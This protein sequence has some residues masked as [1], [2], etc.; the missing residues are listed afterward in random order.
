MHILKSSRFLMKWFILAAASAVLPPW[1]CVAH[2]TDMEIIKPPVQTYAV[3][4]ITG[5]TLSNGSYVADIALDDVPNVA[6][7]TYKND[8]QSY[9]AYKWTNGVPTLGSTVSLADQLTNYPWEGTHWLY[10]GPQ[11]IANGSIAL[12]KQTYNPD[13]P[14]PWMKQLQEPFLADGGEPGRVGLPS[15]LSWIGT[16]TGYGGMRWIASGSAYAFMAEYSFST[17]DPTHQD[18]LGSGRGKCWSSFIFHNG[19]YD[20]FLMPNWVP[21]NDGTAHV[22]N[23]IP[24]I[25]NEQGCGCGWDPVSTDQT[26]NSTQ[27]FWDGRAFSSPFGSLDYPI[28][29]NDQNQVA[30]QAYDSEY[31]STEGYM[32]EPSTVTT[33]RWTLPASMMWQVKS[34]QPI[35]ISNQV[36]PDLP[37]LD[38]TIHILSDATVL[39]LGNS[40]TPGKLV[41]KRDN[42]E[43]WSFSLVKLP[44]QTTI[45]DW[46]TIN[47]RGIIS[48]IGNG[49][50]ALLLLPEDII[51]VD[52]FI[53]QT[54]VEEPV[55]P[56]HPGTTYID[57]GNSRKDPLDSS[58]TS[59]SALF[60]QNSPEFKVRQTLK[61][62]TFP[63]YDPDGSKEEATKKTIVG[64]TRGYEESVLVNGEIPAGS[65]P[66][67]T[68]TATPDVDN[69]IVH[70]SSEES[71][72][73][74][75]QMSVSN[76]LVFASSLAPIQYDIFV[77]IDRSDPSHPTYVIE[78]NSC[79]FPGYEVY[80]NGQLVYHYDPIPGGYR[81]L[82]LLLGPINPIEKTGILTH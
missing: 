41:W 57:N 28:D 38:E 16:D 46:T 59:G 74:E 30:V 47:S 77:K 68:G 2:D 58:L 63:N 25:I 67:A 9:R 7:A 33:L 17:Q 21:M 34:I 6:F 51:Q 81:P 26:G 40:S 31:N 19:S 69:A 27:L 1:I 8:D 39:S 44:D 70:H 62:C 60:I 10:W 50:H 45:S 71:V 53:P 64:E 12:S 42:D 43:K 15:S 54:W 66:I 65:A 56:Y 55:S 79:E 3:F 80:I 11:L 48:A 36:K 52:A 5:T 24:S 18:P 76:P 14:D 13:A 72:V 61:V 82:S 20:S 49:N 37:N 23:F 4:D 29:L 75:F 32:W 73:A 78:G 22:D 35:S